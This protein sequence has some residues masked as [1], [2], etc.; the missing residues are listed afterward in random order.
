MLEPWLTVGNPA[1][2]AGGAL[3]DAVSHTP[4]VDRACRYS[5][6]DLEC[7]MTYKKYCDEY[8]RHQ[9][10]IAGDG[11][12]FCDRC[13]AKHW[14]DWSPQDRFFRFVRVTKTC[15]LWN[16]DKNQYGYG[17]YRTPEKF[18]LAHRYSFM[19]AGNALPVW[20]PGG[21]V[22][23]HICSNPPCVRPSHLRLIT[24]KENLYAGRGAGKCRKGHIFKKG[25]LAGARRCLVCKNEKRKVFS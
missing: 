3:L 12:R 17:R 15:W 19:L 16:G 24:H 1:N 9:W 11:D 10:W 20:I 2:C 13:H 8:P 7:G 6:R 22:L 23:D 21:L 4:F 14:A 5:L 25:T 18:H